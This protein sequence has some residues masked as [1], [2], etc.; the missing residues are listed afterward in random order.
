MQHDE[1]HAITRISRVIWMVDIILIL[2]G[3]MAVVTLF[4]GVICGR[5]LRN[6][7]REYK[8][9][10]EAVDD[11]V[12]SFNRQFQMESEQLRSLAHHVETLTTR[13]DRAIREADEVKKLLP[14]L[15]TEIAGAAS[16][17]EKV[18]AMISDIGGKI[19]TSVVSQ[20]ALVL[21]VA[22][23]E[24][25]AKRLPVLQ[26]ANIEAVIPIRRD[27]ALA[28]L[29]DTEVSVLEMLVKQGPQTAPEIKEAI[30]LSREHTARLMKRLYE[31]GY[32]ERE[33]GKIP[34]RYSVKKEM[35][36]LLRK[37]DLQ[38]S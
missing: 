3:L 36:K 24:E 32:L 6:A 17:R 7:R 14:A 18:T 8:E 37:T 27:K 28:P 33:T 20:E 35:E 12:L 25:Q 11:I 9:A 30:K 1:S 26:E 34:F 10:K 2:E 5:L 31:S 38:T 19:T 16:D 29:T 4:T 13:S 23:L 15:E 21:R 22:S